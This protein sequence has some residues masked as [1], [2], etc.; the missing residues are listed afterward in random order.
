[1]SSLNS[2]SDVAALFVAKQIVDYCHKKEQKERRRRLAY[3]QHKKEMKASRREAVL[4]SVV[5]FLMIG[6]CINMVF[7]DIQAGQREERIAALEAQVSAAKKENSE[8]KKRLA[9]KE[10]Y[11]WVQKEA[12]KLGMSFATADRIYYYMVEEDDFMVQYQ[13]VP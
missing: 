3:I 7:L 8:A 10:D 5:V 4:L 13:D 1:M 11:K 2:L 6:L 9:N 12:E